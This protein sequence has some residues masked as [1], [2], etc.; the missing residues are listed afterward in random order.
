MADGLTYFS[1]SSAL[2]KLP[3][4]QNMRLRFRVGDEHIPGDHR[5]VSMDTQMAGP[6]WAMPHAMSDT[7]ALDRSQYRIPLEFQ[8]FNKNPDLTRAIYGLP[9]RRF[10]CVRCQFRLSSA[11]FCRVRKHHSNV[12]F[13]IMQHFQGTNGVDSL[14]LPFKSDEAT[15]DA[16]ADEDKSEEEDT[17]GEEDG[18]DDEAKKNLA[19]EAAKAAA[20]RE[21]RA[22][23]AEENLL[24]A[25]DA[26]RKAQYLQ[27]QAGRLND[28]EA[29]LS[30]EFI[31]TYFPIDEEDNHYTLGDLLLC[32]GCSNVAHAKCLGLETIPDGDWFCSKCVEEKGLSGQFQPSTSDSGDPAVAAKGSNGME[33]DS[34]KAVTESLDEKTPQAEMDIRSQN[35]ND[36]DEDSKPPADPSLSNDAAAKP[37]E[38]PKK[39]SIPP[40]I[41]DE[42]CITQEE[43]LYTV[44]ESLMCKHEQPK[45]K[46][47]PKPP[48]V[49]EL[50]DDTKAPKRRGRPSKKKSK[51]LGGNGEDPIQALSANALAF[52]ESIGVTT[53][54]D[55]LGAQSTQLGND[56][57]AWRKKQK[58]PPLKGGGHI[59]TISGWKTIVRNAGGV[60]YLS[61]D[62]EEHAE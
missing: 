59:A 28:L 44:I 35:A 14:F 11:F 29:K 13:S 38:A 8:D 20:T 24:K 49:E 48:P 37:R 53:G 45:P 16:S 51:S 56:L 42:E 4:G 50:D 22:K 26:Q 52:L 18:D 57:I 19:E 40:E 31:Q 62:S 41:T 7:I 34:P 54:E 1:P 12:D 39:P 3:K 60:E 33:E 55:F 9:G 32:D 46:A 36:F 21:K 58:M 43:E 2:A 6:A 10:P 15:P 27:I 17:D 5:R 61:D 47:K 23:E 25:Q 30:T